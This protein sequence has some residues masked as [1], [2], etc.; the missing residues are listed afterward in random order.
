MEIITQYFLASDDV[1]IDKYSDK[2]SVLGIFDR[3]YIGKG[4]DSAIVKFAVVGRLILKEI[5]VKSLALSIKILDPDNEE[6]IKKD[7]KIDI[8]SLNKKYSLFPITIK[9]GLMEFKKEGDYKL[10]LTVNESDRSPEGNFV[11]V[12]K[13]II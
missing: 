4:R 8:T 12:E 6:F 2:I 13:I 1:I 7:T 11:S 10:S 9:F 5:D 3:I